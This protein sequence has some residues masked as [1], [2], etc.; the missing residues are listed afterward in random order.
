[1]KRLKQ[2]Y[3]AKMNF[4]KVL[5]VHQPL[6]LSADQSHA[7]VE[8]QAKPNDI[9]LSISSARFQPAEFHR[10]DH[11]RVWFAL[12]DKLINRVIDAVLKANELAHVR[13]ERSLKNMSFIKQPQEGVQS[14]DIWKATHTCY[15]W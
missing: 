12:P 1:M 2:Q 3:T 8:S 7:F 5:R 6:L 13:L 14:V 15:A 11:R 4:L 10:V 9:C